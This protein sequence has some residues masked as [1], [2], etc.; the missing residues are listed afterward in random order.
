MSEQ[1][2]VLLQ[3]PR[4]YIRTWL[5]L[6]G[7][8]IK[9]NGALSKVDE[10]IAPIRTDVFNTAWLDY[11]SQTRAFFAEQKKLATNYRTNLLIFKEKDLEKAFEELVQ[12]E[13]KNIR[14]ASIKA[15]TGTLDPSLTG[16]S[17]FIKS[18]LGRDSDVDTKVLAHWM[19]Q[20]K[21]KLEGK[22]VFYHIMPIFFGPQGSGK[23]VA[24]RKL[25]EPLNDFKLTLTMQQMADER[26]FFAMAE[27]FVSFFDEMQGA[28]RTDIDTLKNQIT[29]DTNSARR[30]GTNFVSIVPQNCSFVGA[31]NRPVS[32]QIID[33]SGM[34]R[35][36]EIKTADKCDWEAINNINYLEL[37]QS[38]DSSLEKGY[39]SEVLDKVIEAQSELLYKD[40]VTV[41]LE[42]SEITPATDIESGVEVSTKLVYNKYK[43]FCEVNGVIR[44]LNSV[45]L[46]RKL[47]NKGFTKIVKKGEGNFYLLKEDLITRNYSPAFKLISNQGVLK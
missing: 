20:V 19:W 31:T 43:E 2:T 10:V 46:G 4:L 36:W 12:G 25:L 9:A 21:R 39:I 6:N 22:S 3:D 23:S 11:I 27:A 45:W 8:K 34:R 37:W 42:E 15:L 16:I 33:G 1:I 26:Y 28:S 5:A 7:Y 13:I 14:K 38:I 17:N 35:F 29:T 47:K 40:E 44:P 41:F 24:I 30:L 32:D 18:V